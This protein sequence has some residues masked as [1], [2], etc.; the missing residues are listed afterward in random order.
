M[1][2]LMIAALTAATAS[3]TPAPKGTKRYIVT[4]DAKAKK[5]D[6]DAALGKMSL[7]ASKDIAT[8]GDTDKEVSGSLVD[9][10]AGRTPPTK[11]AP[12]LSSRI[13]SIEADRRV[14]WIESAQVSFQAAPLPSFNGAMAGFNLDRAKGIVQNPMAPALAAR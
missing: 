9:V 1:T 5:A 2:G 6:R 14:K 8:D 12:P 4:F 7:K 11:S 10:P 13:V 3:A